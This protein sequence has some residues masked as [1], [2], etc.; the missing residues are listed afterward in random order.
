[1]QLVLAYLT[2]RRLHVQVTLAMAAFSIGDMGSHAAPPLENSIDFM[3]AWRVK[4]SMA[5]P[6]HT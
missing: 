4:K 5:T 2:R 3:T 1:M 6:R